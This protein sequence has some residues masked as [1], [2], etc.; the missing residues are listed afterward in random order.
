MSNFLESKEFQETIA[1]IVAPQVKKQVSD[2]ITPSVEKLNVI[3][4]QVKGLHSYAHD[5]KKWQNQQSNRQTDYE[6]NIT[7]MSSTMYDMGSK[8]D[9]L[10]GL[11]QTNSLEADEN[12]PGKR[13]V[14]SLSPEHHAKMNQQYPQKAKFNHL[15]HNIDMTENNDTPPYENEMVSHLSNSQTH[16]QPNESD[17]EMQHNRLDEVG[18][19]Q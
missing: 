5:N 7:T 18:E 9:K 3:E 6:K 8:I 16:S 11:F 2:I 13:N 14:G 10:V 1:K 4:T 17:A 12:P 15:N 19:G